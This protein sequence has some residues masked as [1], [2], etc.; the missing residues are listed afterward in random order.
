MAGK[1]IL[2]ILLSTNVIVRRFSDFD[3]FY[4]VRCEMEA[5]SENKYPRTTPFTLFSDESE[6]LPGLGRR[7]EAG[8]QQL[9]FSNHFPPPMLHH[10]CRGWQ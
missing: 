1:L 5:I 6:I 8:Q 9:S 2:L 4:I 10:G 7:V 3:K